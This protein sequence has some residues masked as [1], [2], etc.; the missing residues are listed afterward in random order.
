[1]RINPLRTTEKYIMQES[2]AAQ[3]NDTVAEWSKAPGSGPGSKERGFK[4]HRC[5]EP[6][7]PIFLRPPF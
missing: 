6:A 1:M 5:H 2:S 3:P 4:S 7:V